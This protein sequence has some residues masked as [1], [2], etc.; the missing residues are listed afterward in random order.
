MKLGAYRRLLKGAAK[1][2]HPNNS[3]LYKIIGYL[4]SPNP[5]VIPIDETI[6]C[7]VHSAIKGTRILM[8]RL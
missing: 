7:R 1:L 8:L 6:T 3:V 4:H 2:K 5:V